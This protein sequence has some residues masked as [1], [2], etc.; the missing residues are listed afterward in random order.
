VASNNYG[1]DH[2]TRFSVVR[3]GNVMGSRG[4]VIP[5]LPVDCATRGVLPITDPRMTR[6]MISLEQGVELVWHAFE[7]HGRRRDLRPRSPR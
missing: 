3:Y 7:R 1:G 2:G 5:V 6:F 4:S